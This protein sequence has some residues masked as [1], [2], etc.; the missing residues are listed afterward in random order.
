MA[1]HP[2]DA[3]S[4]RDVDIDLLQRSI[5]RLTKTIEEWPDKMER[6][7]VRADVYAKDQII[8]ANIH[9]AQKEDISGLQKIVAGAIGFILAGVGAAILKTVLG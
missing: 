8:H 3:Q 7:Y 4:R 1:P 5:E 6:L 2:D 9:T